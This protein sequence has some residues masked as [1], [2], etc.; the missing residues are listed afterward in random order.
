MPGYGS[1]VLLKKCSYEG[2]NFIHSNLPDTCNVEFTNHPW[3]RKNWQN[4]SF[5]SEAKSS[6]ILSMSEETGL[7][8]QIDFITSKCWYNTLRLPLLVP[9]TVTLDNP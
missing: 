1:Y 3:K 7:P 4:H 8:P 5:I 9:D 2:L 6:N